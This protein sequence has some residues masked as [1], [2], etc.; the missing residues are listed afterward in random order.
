MDKIAFSTLIFGVPLNFQKQPSLRLA[1]VSAISKQC[2]FF[3]LSSYLQPLKM[4][5]LW[6]SSTD[7]FFHGQIKLQQTMQDPI[8][9]LL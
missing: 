1:G 5:L 6:E 7:F 3:S 9:F 2:E 8:Y 4:F